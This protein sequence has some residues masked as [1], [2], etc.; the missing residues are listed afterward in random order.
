MKRGFRNI[1][2]QMNS[3]QNENQH[4]AS[5]QNQSQ[6]KPGKQ[7]GGDYIDFEEIK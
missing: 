1:H 3:H 4:S 5:Q 6:P 2:N 7:S